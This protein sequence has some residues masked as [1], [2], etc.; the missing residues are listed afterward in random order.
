MRQ[1]S[2]L[3]DS[4]C[5]R[6]HEII[7]KGIFRDRSNDHQKPRK[8][9]KSLMP[10]ELIDQL[11]AQVQNKDAESILGEAGLAGQLK[12]LLAERMLT[13]RFTPPVPCATMD[14]ALR[15]RSLPRHV[16]GRPVRLGR[17]RRPEQNTRAGS[18]PHRK[19]RKSYS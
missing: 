3:S 5:D 7:P 16:S 6:G 15:L 13:S 4:L 12:K 9:I 11:L 14:G 1:R 19:W 10:V 2:S 8:K 18:P 17:A